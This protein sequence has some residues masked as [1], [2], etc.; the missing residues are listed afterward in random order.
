MRIKSENGGDVELKNWLIS[1]TV[2]VPEERPASVA[3]RG[4]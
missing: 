4:Y 3:R 2:L 1:L